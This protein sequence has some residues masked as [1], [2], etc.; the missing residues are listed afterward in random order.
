MKKIKT[1]PVSD[2]RITLN[3]SSNNKTIRAIQKELL[4]RDSQR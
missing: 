1:I 4:R 2:L 3:T